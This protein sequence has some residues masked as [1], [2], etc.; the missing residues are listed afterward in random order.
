MIRLDNLCLIIMKCYFEK[1]F[2]RDTTFLQIG[3]KSF[4]LFSF[5]QYQGR[6]ESLMGMLCYL[7]NRQTLPWQAS[8]AEGYLWLIYTHF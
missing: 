8:Q 3:D 2:P 5:L 6:V 4:H 1:Y 7:L